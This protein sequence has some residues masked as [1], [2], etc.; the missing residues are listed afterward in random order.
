MEVKKNPKA[1]LTRKT[2]FFFSIA[3]LITMSIVLTAFE[4]KQSEAAIDDLVQRRSDNFEAMVD[5][6]PTEIIPPRPSV[7]APVIEEVSDKEELEDIIIIIDVLPTDGPLEPIVFKPVD[8]I[9]EP[10]DE[11]FVSPESPASFKGGYDA[12]YKYVASK[13]KYPVQARRMTIEGKVYVEFVINRDGSV[14][15]VR[16]VKGIGAGCDEEAMRVI[17]SSPMWNPGKQRGVPVRQKMV[18]PIIFKLSN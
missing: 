17:E 15:N 16:L 4:W 11:P 14:T 18:L 7:S 5:V 13:I 6:L 9:Y 8:V 3:L 12:F 10:T 2:G 1:D